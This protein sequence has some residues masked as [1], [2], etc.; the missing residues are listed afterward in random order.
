[1][2]QKRLRTTDRRRT[3][4]QN[5]HQK[6]VNKGALRSCRWGAWHSNL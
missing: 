2:R 1:M 6:D 4:T 3:V 5:R